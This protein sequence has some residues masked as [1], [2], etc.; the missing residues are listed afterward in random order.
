[1]NT[2]LWVSETASAF[3][4]DAGGYES[5]PRNLRVPIA[6]SLPLAVVSLPALRLASVELWMQEQGIPYG[7]EVGD[8]RLRACLVARYGQGLIFLDGADPEDEQRF[9]LAHELAHFLRDYWAP[10]RVVS[11]RLGQG[12][13]EVLDGDRPPRSEERMHA[14]LA[15]VQIGFH[16]HLMGRSSEGGIVDD[17]IEAS[18]RDADRLAFELLAP[19]DTVLKEVS[20]YP[21]EQH[22]AMLAPLLT[23][24]FGLPAPLANYYV[25]LLMPEPR[26]ESSLVRRLGLAP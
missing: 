22:R 13:L 16:V 18:E 2:P 25:S 12:V 10:R 26:T 1:M 21:N 3:W 24:N 8:R 19:S 11:D 20:R 4:A 7:V 9:S 6:N 5:F 15:R 14:L 17:A 23:E